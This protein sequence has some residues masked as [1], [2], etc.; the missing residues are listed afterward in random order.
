MTDIAATIDAN[1]IRILRE[2]RLQLRAELDDVDDELVALGVNPHL[3]PLIVAILKAAAGPL[4]G[5]LL[6]DRTCQLMLHTHGWPDYVR[7]LDHL[8]ADGKIVPVGAGRW[9]VPSRL[10]DP[11]PAKTPT[12][13]R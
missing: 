2:R 11:D 1:T 12:D 7:H 10:V 9:T 5:W 3:E 13:A 8:H 6:W 4:G